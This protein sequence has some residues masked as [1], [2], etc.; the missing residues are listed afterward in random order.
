MNIDLSMGCTQ[1]ELAMVCGVSQPAISALMTEGK[2][3]AGGTFGELLLAYCQH[4]RKQ[5]AE[6]IGSGVLDLV[7][8][9][10]ALAKEQCISQKLKND[11]AR[12]EYSPT[13][14]LADV[15]AVVS[16]A[17][18]D[19]IDMLEWSIV[20][21][22]PTLP[23]DARATV[24]QVIA[25]ARREWISSTDRKALETSDAGEADDSD[26]DAISDAQDDDSTTI[27]Q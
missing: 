14:L 19:R 4:L 17:V 3:P 9:R 20:Q 10:A 27:A 22:C 18:V 1:S 2:I 16:A 5:A 23:D 13:G 8:E 24:M 25:S 12:S 26:D 7:Q 21:A 11:A 15:L 6:R